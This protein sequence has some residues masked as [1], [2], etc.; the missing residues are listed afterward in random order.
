M[1]SRRTFAPDIRSF[2]YSMEDSS[3]HPDSA[4]F[5]TPLDWHGQQPSPIKF[6]E[7]PGESFFASAVSMIRDAHSL[8]ARLGR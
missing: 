7:E 1:P 3:R 8:P 2:T 5:P 6:P 4:Q